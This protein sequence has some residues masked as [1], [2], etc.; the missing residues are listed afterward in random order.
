M[1]VG[2]RMEADLDWCSAWAEGG[3][4]WVCA[5]VV[6]ACFVPLGAEALAAPLALAEGLLLALP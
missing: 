3:V 1:V 5:E 6:V 4:V 2:Q